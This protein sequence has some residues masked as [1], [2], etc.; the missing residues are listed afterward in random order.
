MKK[1]KNS[2]KKSGVDIS[3][4][5]KLVKHISKVSKKNV[6]KTNAL[7]D[8]DLIGGFGSF[9]D[10]SKIKIKDPVIVSCT[11]GVGT[12]IELANKFKKFDTIGI[13]LVAM[14][15]NDLIV[16]GAKPLFFLDYIA[17]GKLNLVKV[18]KIINGIFNGCR[19][20]DCKLVGG[21]TAEMPGVYSKEK[22]DL[23]GFSVGI[24]SKK[25][26]LKK[27]NVEKGD[28]IMAIPSSGIH[29]NGYSLIRSIIKDIKLTEELKSELIKP[30]K[31]YVKEILELTNK[32][33]INAAAHIT[34]GGLIENLLRSVPNKYSLNIGSCLTLKVLHILSEDLLL[35]FSNHYA[36]HLKLELY[37][38]K[39]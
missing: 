26:I 29:S 34:G 30:T 39:K 8:K 33:L 7:F 10:I 16:Q 3:L 25:K 9:Y 18:K 5:N 12:K 22:F 28:I 23:A 31:I 19:L 38:V 20:S 37:I 27:E 4:A 14:C 32:R 24:V 35:N 17:V 6:Q 13:D 15:V 21:E 11:D 2:Y 1:I 36:K